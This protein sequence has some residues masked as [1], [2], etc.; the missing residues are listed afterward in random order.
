MSLIN[1]IILGIVEG[2][3]EFLPISST[4]HLVLVSRLLGIFQS[5][6]VKSFEIIIQ[7][8]AIL[9]VMLIY[10]KKIWPF[11]LELWKR[12]LVSFIPTAVIGFILY[13][14]IKGF[15]IGNIWISATALIAGGIVIIIFEKMARKHQE[16]MIDPS[17]EMRSL[18]YKKA[19]LIGLVQSIAVIPG[20]SRSA[21]TIVGGRSLGMS[22]QAI[23]EYS[24]LLAIP[25]I[26]AASGYD[27]L[28]SGFNF[29]NDQF[30]LLIVGFVVSF[31]V[32]I[33]AVRFL[34]RFLRTHD[35][36]VFGIYRI[37]IGIIFLFLI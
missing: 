9:A 35:F 17:I 29:T 3:T 10:R 27:L 34:L 30:R 16:A 12:V 13:K 20:V 14:V 25:T 28:K 1:S 21:A 24:F 7:F 8:G 6:F 23:I 36:T 5:D 15:L 32:A 37:L 11:D 22:R 4:A 33:F 2:I 26:L 19:F 18:S 31:V